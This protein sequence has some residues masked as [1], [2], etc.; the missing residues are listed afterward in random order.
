VLLVISYRIS[1]VG[2]DQ[3]KENDKKAFKH[4]GD[5]GL[6]V[7]AIEAEAGGARLDTY[8]DGRQRMDGRTQG[9]VDRCRCH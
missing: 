3:K 6:H 2:E 5:R 1:D 9:R 8:L 7:V 4:R